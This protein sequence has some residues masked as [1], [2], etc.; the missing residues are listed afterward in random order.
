M[1]ASLP[2]GH[3][4]R[5]VSADAPG[6]AAQACGVVQASITHCCAA[7]HGHDVAVL[8]AWLANKTPDNLAAWM[9][10]PGAMAWGVY[11]EEGATVQMVGFALVSRPATLALC[12]L[13]PEALHQG[14]GRELLHAAEAGARQAGAHA[15]VLDSTRTALP[16]YR[17]NGYE[18]LGEAKA[19]AGLWAQPM[20][21]LL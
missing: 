10:A 4:I 3:A 21:K 2:S 20:R 17:R 19:W 8:R 6:A 18:P 13:L 12:Y 7:D 1:T 16:F 11:R 9:S 15:L 14:I 5:Q